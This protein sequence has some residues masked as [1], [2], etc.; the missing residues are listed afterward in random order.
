M[1]GPRRRDV[2][3]AGA[4]AR[5]A[6]ERELADDEH[7]AVAER[8]VHLAVGVGEDA[9]RADLVGELVARR[10]V[11]VVGDAEQDEQAGADLADGRPVDADGGAG[12]PLDESAHGPFLVS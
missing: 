9:Q 2:A 4:L 10:V 11:V 1:L 5:V 6:V 3:R 12:D 7:L 8:L